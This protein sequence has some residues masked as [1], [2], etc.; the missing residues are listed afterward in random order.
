MAENTG[1]RSYAFVLAVCDLQRSIGYFESVLGFRAEWGDGAN[2]QALS[3]EGVR[4]ML[5]H[6]PDAKPPT[7]M[8]DHSYFAY[9]HV[10]DLDALHAEIAQRGAIIRQP[11]T[12]RAWGM[13]EMEIATPDG[14]RM[15]VGQQ[16]STNL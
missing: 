10:D 12:N 3:R 5:G 2:W 16:I 11:P 13:R 14:H 4:V 1:F 6:C 8:G 7:E 9:L 15:V